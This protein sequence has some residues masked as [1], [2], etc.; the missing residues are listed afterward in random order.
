MNWVMV[1]AVTAGAF[2]ALVFV[3]KLPRPA[4]ELT[5]SVMLIG[6]AGYAAQGSPGLTGSP[7]PPRADRESNAALLVET[8]QSMQAEFAPGRRYLITADAMARNGQFASA[9][10]ILRGAI[11]AHPDDPDAWLALGNALLMHAHGYPS[12]AAFYAYRRAGQ[13]DRNQFNSHSTLLP[14]VFIHANAFQ[15]RLSAPKKAKKKS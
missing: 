11:R 9:A 12:P 10:A 6:L 2:A 4:W 3:L 14:V 7:T 1:I 15:P 13:A 8:R 5:G